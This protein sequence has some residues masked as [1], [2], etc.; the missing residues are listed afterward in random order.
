MKLSLAF[1]I[2]ISMSLI[3]LSCKKPDLSPNGSYTMPSEE[4][5]HE[6]TWLQWPH[7]H[8][9]PNHITRHEGTFVEITRALH[10]GERV[11]II[12]YNNM[13]KERIA[14][15]LIAEGIDMTQIDL[16][17]SENDD[18][19]IRDNGPIFVR[20]E[21]GAPTIQNWG[22]N[23]WGDKAAFEKCNLVP[24]NIGEAYG[25]PVVNVDLINEGG[26]VELD[27]NGTLMAKKSS[28]L[29]RNRNPGISQKEA[30]AVFTKYLG[31][32]NFIWLRGYKGG[33]ITDDHIDGT[34]RFVNGNTIVTL[35]EEDAY[36][37]EYDRIANA[38]NVDGEKYTIVGLPFTQNKLPG[39]EEK[40]IY[41]NFYIGNEVVLV[42]NFDDP[43]DALA[44]EII[45]ELFPDKTVV[46]IPAVEL[47]KDG[48]GVHCVTQQQP[49]F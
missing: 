49:L 30:E 14:S 32:T 16:F 25:F 40:G 15:V 41:V 34:A 26:S 12:A 4:T 3:V 11:H 13:E 42:P 22:F 36:P 7:D 43:N 33:D 45:Q 17:I 6:G 24:K 29:N 44:N 27:G 31:V 10:T 46:G 9:Y 5:A 48:G 47:G 39:T 19:W 23:G 20:D 35:R 28:I 1:I 38:T 18:Y 37:G 21:N 2:A 8:T